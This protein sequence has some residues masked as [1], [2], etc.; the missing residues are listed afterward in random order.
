[1]MCPPGW[2]RNGV[3]LRL[4]QPGMP[5]ATTPRSPAA[6]A[7]PTRAWC[8]RRDEGRRPMTLGRWTAFAVLL[9]GLASPAV[10]QDADH[11]QGKPM[12]VGSDFGIAPWMVRGAGGPEGF[13]VDL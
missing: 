11:P 9:L 1:M 5:G 13:G 8:Y 6:V 2:G 10:A 7:E 12:V 4:S 3:R